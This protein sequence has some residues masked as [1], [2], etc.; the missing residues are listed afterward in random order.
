MPDEQINKAK[1]LCSYAE[2]GDKTIREILQWSI[3]KCDK[4]EVTDEVQKLC[5]RLKMLV[6]NPN[7]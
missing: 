3:L 4:P 1:P 2:A 7:W 6:S 5:S